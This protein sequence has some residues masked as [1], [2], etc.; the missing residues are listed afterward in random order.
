M[1]R[2]EECRYSACTHERSTKE[3]VM[4]PQAPMTTWFWHMFVCAVCSLFA[5]FGV[6]WW[7][8]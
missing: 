7:I 6:S 1:F 3:Y 8:P 4:W 5:V 2:A